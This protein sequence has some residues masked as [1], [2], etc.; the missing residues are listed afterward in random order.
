MHMIHAALLAWIP[1]ILTV[2]L[3]AQNREAWLTAT[4]VL[5]CSPFLVVGTRAFIRNEGG[6]WDM[7]KLTCLT[8]AGYGVGCLFVLRWLGQWP[9][10][11]N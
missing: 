3:G 9:P 5:L 10:V 7:V 4:G 11:G 8:A 6:K 1:A 2:L